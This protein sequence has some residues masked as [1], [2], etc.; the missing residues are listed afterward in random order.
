[1]LCKFAY[2]DKEGGLEIR[3]NPKAIYQTM[4]EV[5]MSIIALA[6]FFLRRALLIG[7]RYAVCR[8]QF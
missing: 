1:M 6:G 3:G 2:I 5:R 4:V 8:R 7:L